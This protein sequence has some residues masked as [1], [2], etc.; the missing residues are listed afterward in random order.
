VTPNERAQTAARKAGRDTYQ[1]AVVDYWPACVACSTPI[2]RPV[3]TDRR[4]LWRACGCPDVLW[5]CTMDGWVKWTD[6]PAHQP[7]ADS[8]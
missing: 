6:V 4:G 1:H 7:A 3:D 5:S 2:R 8:L